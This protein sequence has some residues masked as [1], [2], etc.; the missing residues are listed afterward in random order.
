MPIPRVV[1]S[2][3]PG[4]PILNGYHGSAYNVMK[5]ALDLCG[6]T[7]EFDD[8]EN[9]TCVFRNNPIT[10]SGCYVRIVDN[11]NHSLFQWAVFGVEVYE[12]MSDV[13]TGFGPHFS[14][15]D[16]TIHSKARWPDPQD[17]S[18]PWII[19]GD[20]RTIYFSFNITDGQGAGAFGDIHSLNPNTKSFQTYCSNLGNVS[21]FPYQ[22]RMSAS[23]IS[24]TTDNVSL[25]RDPF[26]NLM[27]PITFGYR[28]SVPDLVTSAPSAIGG[29]TQPP[30]YIDEMRRFSFP[31]IITHP[32][33][34]VL[35]KM[36]G[37]TLPY[38]SCEDL[39]WASEYVA[40][41]GLSSKKFI[42]ITGKNTTG[43]GS[44]VGTNST[45]YIF[46]EVERDWDDT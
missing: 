4:S 3:D 20:D 30:F 46:V 12:D 15:T 1:R 29:S 32:T 37:I 9:F 23:L 36:R 16:D 44:G 26:S 40:A 7:L 22:N 35:G 33:Y 41:D 6:W 45:G 2:T 34:G 27:K 24:S 13:N 42:T 38:K 17:V 5:H 21:S 11:M 31:A 28:Y 19:I 8:P 10:G 39:P 25:S 43:A 14:V 18:W